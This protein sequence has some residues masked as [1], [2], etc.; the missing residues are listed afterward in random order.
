MAVSIDLKGKR[1]VIW[2]V[3]NQR[4]IAWAISERLAEAGAELAFTYLNE[5]LKEP[6]EKATAGLDNPIL[7]ECDATNDEQ[8]QGVYDR[9]KEEWGEIDFVVHCIA[10]AERDDLGG[11]FSATNLQGFRTALETSAYTLMPVVGKAA[12]LF[13]ESGG[14]AITLTFDASQRVYPGYNIM[15]TAKAALENEARQ[16]AVEFGPSNI[17]VNAIS[18]GPL[19]TLAARSIPGFRDMTRAHRERSPLNRNINH[20][21]VADTALFLLSDMSSGITGSIIPV[22]AGY[23]IIAL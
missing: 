6:V 23:G 2:G 8:V 13:G 19:P 17:R 3:A 21:E 22:D 7:L 5:R 20:K 10:Y 12:P 4:S 14:S 11:D 18:A 9:I 16:L 1:G 15:G